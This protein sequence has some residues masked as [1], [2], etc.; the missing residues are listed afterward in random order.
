MLAS[1]QLVADAAD[2]T[3]IPHLED[4]TEDEIDD[5]AISSIGGGVRGK[6]AKVDVALPASIYLILKYGSR[7]SG[8]LMAAMRANVMVGGDSASRAAAIGMVL[9]AVEGVQAIPFTF[10]HGLE[11]WIPCD[12]HL[13]AL[14]VLA[15]ARA[16]ASNRG[17]A[18]G[19]P[20]GGGSSD[21]QYDDDPADDDGGEGGGRS[22]AL[23]HY[24]E[25]QQAAINQ[26]NSEPVALGPGNGFELD[27]W[28]I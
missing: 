28:V 23:S 11:Q 16:E 18:P 2:R 15:K 26:Q 17:Q 12:R 20:L 19:P 1:A 9:G 27:G 3:G 7:S 14:P 24:E 10:Q 4:A 5:V 22:D 25:Q 21:Y 13:G 6:A 8:G